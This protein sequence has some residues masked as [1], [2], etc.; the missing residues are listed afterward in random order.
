MT[1]IDMDDGQKRIHG[2]TQPGAW[3]TSIIL[4]YLPE[5]PDYISIGQ[6]GSSTL[7][8]KPPAW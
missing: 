7:D 4:K 1:I 8:I 6:G 5:C 2:G 3:L